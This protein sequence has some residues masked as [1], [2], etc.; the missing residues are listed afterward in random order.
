GEDLYHQRRVVGVLS[1]SATQAT[2]HDEVVGV[3]P[4]GDPE[5]IDLSGGSR[6]IEAAA[7]AL[8]DDEY[9]AREVAAGQPGLLPPG[10]SLIE[11]VWPPPVPGAAGG[12][13]AD[14]HAADAMA[15]S[16]APPGGGTA[17]AGAGMAATAP[18]ALA[19]LGALAVPAAGPAE[20][21]AALAAPLPA[22]ALAAP[23]A[24]GLPEGLWGAAAALPGAAA[25]P[26][27]L[28]APII[29]QPVPVTVETTSIGPH[30]RIVAP[31]GHEMMTGGIG[32]HVPAGGGAVLVRQIRSDQIDEH[33]GLEA[34]G[35]ARI[36]SVVSVNG[37]RARRPWRE[38]VAAL[39][40]VPFPDWATEGPRTA[41]WC[42]RWIDRRGG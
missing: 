2:G 38:V 19:P 18:L 32:V 4:D 41:L 6:D 26:L 27:A 9:V 30:G 12:A 42:C 35:E 21:A 13:A 25:A 24:A 11:S 37:L 10:G 40:E 7:T 1:L 22:G 31:N 15:G 8:C 5:R 34:A 20:P 39:T 33:K 17:V 23:V 16:G 3:S 36:L 29:A 28:P 14:G